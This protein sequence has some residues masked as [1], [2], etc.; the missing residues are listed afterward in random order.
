MTRFWPEGLPLHVTMD[1]QHAPVTLLWDGAQHPVARVVARWRVDEGWWR[2]RV[3]REY[4]T[5][6]TGTGLLLTLFHDLRHDA[7]RLQRVY[8]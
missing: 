5:V 2:W 3:W 4:F 7:W 8:D 1:D 6:A